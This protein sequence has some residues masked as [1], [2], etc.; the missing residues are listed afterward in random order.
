MAIL[1]ES[2]G[3]PLVFLETDMN[4]WTLNFPGRKVDFQD[5]CRM[6]ESTQEKKRGSVFAYEPMWV[7]GSGAT[8]G[9]NKLVI[10]EWVESGEVDTFEVLQTGELVGGTVIGL[11]TYAQLVTIH[12]AQDLM[13]DHVL[14]ASKEKERAGLAKRAEQRARRRD[15]RKFILKRAPGSNIGRRMVKESN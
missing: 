4:K 5:Y 9:S 11:H 1:G 12:N 8:Y 2:F 3:A 14:E 7:D 6:V 15:L 10:A 13:W